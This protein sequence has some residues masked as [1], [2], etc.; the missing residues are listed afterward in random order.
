MIAF[1]KKRARLLALF[2]FSH[3]LFALWMQSLADFAMNLS[4]YSR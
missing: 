1:N 3:L 2:L 4:I